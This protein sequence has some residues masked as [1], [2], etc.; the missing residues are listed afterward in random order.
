ML[1]EVL[2]EIKKICKQTNKQKQ[3][4]VILKYKYQTKAVRIRIIIEIC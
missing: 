3:H 2:F 1:K 4:E